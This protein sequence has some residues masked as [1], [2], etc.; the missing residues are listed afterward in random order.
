MN[1]IFLSGIH[2]SGST[3]VS[4]VLASSSELVLIQEP[5]NLK[6]HTKWLR[7]LEYWYQF[8]SKENGHMFYGDFK[9]CVNLNYPFVRSI[10]SSTTFAGLARIIQNSCSTSI[11]HYLNKR[12]IIKDPLAIFSLEWLKDNFNFDIIILIRH[13]A[14]FVGS[15]KSAKWNH[16]F[17]HF[18]KQSILL[19]K[20]LDPFKFEIE[21]YSKTQKDIVDQGILMWNIVHHMILRYKGINPDWI[22]VKHEQLSTDPQIEFGNIFKQLDIA[23]SK[24]IKKI[25]SK[26]SNNTHR[27]YSYNNIKRNSKLN[28]FS[29]KNRLTQ[30][31]IDK[32]KDKTSEISNNFYSEEDWADDYRLM[33]QA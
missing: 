25:I 2:R 1:P 29:W 12:V 30:Y 26:Y 23:Y 33:E 24:N 18:I 22:F 17:D 11:S 9:N 15:I 13:P 7:N 19:D 20:Y 5:C 8:I 14:A 27:E 6:N 28:I 32:I 21:E 31:E 3:W 10:L 16:P 4:K